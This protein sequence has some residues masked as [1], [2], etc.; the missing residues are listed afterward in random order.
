MAEVS[1]QFGK[2]EALASSSLDSAE[3]LSNMREKTV[4]GMQ[5]GRIILSTRDWFELYGLHK[6]ATAGTCRESPPPWWKHKP[7]W[8]WQ[9]WNAQGDMSTIEAKAKF[10]TGIRKVP[11]FEVHFTEVSEDWFAEL[12]LCSGWFPCFDAPLHSSAASS[13]ASPPK[14]KPVG[15]KCPG[16]RFKNQGIGSTPILNSTSAEVAPPSTSAVVDEILGE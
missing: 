10:I 16:L 9:A 5:D 6:V 15:E 3:C 11:G 8:K 4:S 12:F 1:R 13:A 2:V 14:L 7:R